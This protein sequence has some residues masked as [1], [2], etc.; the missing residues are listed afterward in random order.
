MEDAKKNKLIIE[1]PWN[2]KFESNMFEI[3][4]ELIIET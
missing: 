2:A 4:T 1:T 3:G